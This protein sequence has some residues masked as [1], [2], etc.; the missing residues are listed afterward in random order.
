MNV[1]HCLIDLNSERIVREYQP[2]QLFF[3][4]ASSFI[5]KAL[6]NCPTA[7]YILITKDIAMKIKPKQ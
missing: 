7:N 3:I 6:L 1:F 4:K 2:L 5:G